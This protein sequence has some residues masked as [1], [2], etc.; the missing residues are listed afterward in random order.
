MNL[1]IKVFNIKGKEYGYI[2]MEIVKTYGFR[3]ACLLE[4]AMT[5]SAV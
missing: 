3:K 1:P 5:L 2:K 4:A